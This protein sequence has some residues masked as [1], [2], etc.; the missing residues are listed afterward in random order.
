MIKGAK[1]DLSITGDV[2]IGF[3]GETE[4]DFQGT[5]SLVAEV[6]YDGLYIFKYSPRPQTPASAYA[7]SILDEVKTERFLRLQELQSRIQKLRYSGYIGREVEV[8]V[9]GLSARSTSDCTGHT[10]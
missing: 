1:K 4:D 9:E 10:R 2:I 7:D 6:E 8:L 5:L 3:P